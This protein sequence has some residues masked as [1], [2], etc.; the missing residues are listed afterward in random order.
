MFVRNVSL[1]LKPNTITEFVQ[2]MDSEIILTLA[3]ILSG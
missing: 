3:T 2:T 1:Y